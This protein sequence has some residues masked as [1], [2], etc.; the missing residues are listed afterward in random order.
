MRVQFQ[1]PLHYS[2]YFSHRSVDELL[3]ATNT[4]GAVAIPRN[5]DRLVT[6]ASGAVIDHLERASRRYPGF[7]G[8]VEG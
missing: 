1:I 8:S 7:R 2:L 5:P 3:M 6:L 4:S